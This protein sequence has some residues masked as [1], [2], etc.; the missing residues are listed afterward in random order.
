M[1]INRCPICC[2]PLVLRSYFMNYFEYDLEPDGKMHDIFT[3]PDI[4]QRTHTKLYC[5]SCEKSWFC[6][7]DFN[8]N[9]VKYAAFMRQINTNKQDLLNSK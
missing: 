5:K 3:I 9:K 7:V 4:H 1:Q 6:D 8:E 2:R